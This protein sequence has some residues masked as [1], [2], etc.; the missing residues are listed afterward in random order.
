MPGLDDGESGEELLPLGQALEMMRFGF[1]KPDV[2][3]LSDREQ[4]E[5][6]RGLELNIAYIDREMREPWATEL[7]VG[8]IRP[9][10]AS[11][12]ARAEHREWTRTLLANGAAWAGKLAARARRRGDFAMAEIFED[13]E[14]VYGGDGAG[15]T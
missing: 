10:D 6:R 5:P 12:E 14:R 8:R 7:L 1:F 15:S 2:G 3:R 9:R 13:L 4:D 11:P